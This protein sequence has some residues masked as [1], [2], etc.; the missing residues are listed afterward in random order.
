MAGEYDINLSNG[1]ILATLHPMEVN[2]PDNVST[3]RQIQSVSSTG[4]TFTLAGDMTYRFVAGFQFEVWN[5]A[6]PT[7]NDYSPGAGGSFTFTDTQAV[8]SPVEGV[9]GQKFEIGATFR[10]IGSNGVDG[11]YTVASV[12]FVPTG[13]PATGIGETTVVV[14]E[15]VPTLTSSPLIYG[16]IATNDGTYTVGVGGSTYTSGTTTIPVVENVPSESLPLGQIIYTIL[17]SRT[18]LSLPGRGTVNYGEYLIDSFVHVLENFA[19]DVSPDVNPNLGTTPYGQALVGQWW[20]NTTTG[21][22]GFKHFDGTAWTSNFDVNDGQ[23][24]FLDPENPN[25]ATTDIILTGSDPDYPEAGATLRTL[26]NPNAGDAIFRVLSAGGAERLRVEHDGDLSTGNTLE[27][28]A[29]TGTYESFIDGTLAIGGLLGTGPNRAAT[30]RTL[31]VQGNGIAV[32]ADLAQNATLLLDAPTGMLSHIGFQ[33]STVLQSNITVD[34][35]VDGTLHLNSLTANDVTLATGG[36]DVGIRTTPSYPLDVLGDTRILGYVGINNVPPSGAVRLEVTGD[37]QVNSQIRGSNGTYDVPTFTF[38]NDLTTGMWYNATGNELTFSGGA[39]GIAFGVGTAQPFRIEADGTVNTG[40]TV[41]YYT[42]VT[43]TNDIPNKGYLDVVIQPQIDDLNQMH[44]IMSEPT[45][46]PNRTDSVISFNEGTNTFTIAP[47]GSSYDYYIDGVKTTVAI[48]K[49]FTISDTE[50][51]H[52][53]YFSDNTG[54]LSEMPF[55]SLD[56]LES[57]AYCTAIYWDAT[58]KKLIYFADERHGLTMDS[59]THA[60]LHTVNGARYMS[61]FAL[62][63]FNTDGLGSDNASARFACEGGSLRDEDLLHTIVDGTP[64]TLSPIAQIPVLYRE[65]PDGDWRI[66]AADDYP[67]IYNGTAGYTGTLLPFNEW[68]GS[69]AGWQLTE[70][71][72]TNF[73]MTH[74][75]ATN[76]VYIPVIGIQGQAEYNTIIDAYNGALSELNSL[77]GLPFQEFV[78]LGT[79]I[80]EV[81]N[82]YSNAVK[83]RI[84]KTDGGEDYVDWRTTD[85]FTSAVGGGALTDHGN[86]SGLT[87]DDHPQYHNDARGDA[88]YYTQT[89]LDSGQ[90]DSRYYTETELNGGQL[91]TLYVNKTGDSMTGDLNMQDHL[92]VRPEIKDYAETITIT[93]VSGTVNLDLT[94]GNVFERT[95]TGNTTFS[96]TNPPASGSAGSLTLILKQDAV[97]GYAITWPTSVMWAGGTAPTLST[98]AN[99]IDV[100]TFVTVDG[101]TSWYGFLSGANFS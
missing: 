91:D 51:M 63:G 13:S 55:F 50:G 87:D 12:S 75:F 28:L 62:S 14:A 48:T 18:T 93:S 30:D 95:I 8:G 43:D 67:V 80:W 92:I 56:L 57:G 88:R 34:S 97:G 11:L 69:P 53:I 52:F 17:D 40:D 47:T 85:T 10:V 66:K 84:R 32:H 19:A 90:L 25:D 23:L 15:T 42:L 70:V 6:G 3:P 100:L 54:T 46:F 98:A 36:G 16:R 89:Q 44:I 24:I 1:S 86:L 65:G 74:Y 81:N 99:A 20:Y 101:G 49:N 83:A 9:E 79:V 71:A 2:G 31:T 38:T 72:N 45:G 60:Y 41:D 61:G 76:D 94:T 27:V 4:G 21:S 78:P 64:Q 82:T 39:G 68:T 26:V 5:S 7:I 37:V 58:N 96:F 35:S 33:T 29:T 59:A 73:V 22:E 77:A